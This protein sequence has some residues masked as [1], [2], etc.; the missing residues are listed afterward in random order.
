MEVA[1]REVVADTATAFARV[2]PASDRQQHYLRIAESAAQGQIPSDLVAPLE[3]MLDVVLQG[4]EGGPGAEQ[5]LLGVF[6][7]TPRGA[8]LA[9]ATHDVN[10][11]LV[12]LRGQTLERLRVDTRPGRHSL[13]LETDRCRMVIRLDAA[14]PRVES[15][16][17]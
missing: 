7:R 16:E 17:V 15:L 3:T 4:R 14:G 10:E 1:E 13:T 5:A 12:A 11:A 6:R 8:T 9:A 2:L